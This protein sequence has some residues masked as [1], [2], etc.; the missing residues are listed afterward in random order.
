MV[1]TFIDWIKELGKQ[2][3]KT[4]TAVL[5]FNVIVPGEYSSFPFLVRR[6][7]SEQGI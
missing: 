5:E 3:G 1:E 2:S 6:A 4:E 7:C